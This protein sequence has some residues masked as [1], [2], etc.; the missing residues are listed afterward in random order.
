MKNTECQPMAKRLLS[1]LFAI[2]LVVGLVPISAYAAND[3]AG[4]ETTQSQEQQEPQGTEGVDAG[5]GNSD[6]A[7][8]ASETQD[9]SSD[10]Q[11]TASEEDSVTQAENG[12]N[13]V[14]QFASI[15]GGANAVSNEPSTVADKSLT[16]EVDGTANITNGGSGYSHSWETSNSSIATAKDNSGSASWGSRKTG[17]AIVTGVKPGTVTI[18]HKYK[19]GA[20]IPS[21]KSET[22]TVEVVKAP[23][24][25]HVKLTG[26][27]V[28]AVYD[29][30][31]HAAGTAT[32][33]GNNGHPVVVEYQKADGSWTKNPADITA[34]AVADSTTVNVRASVPDYYDGYVTTTQALTIVQHPVVFSGDLGPST[35]TDNGS[36]NATHYT[37]G[38]ATVLQSGQAANVQASASSTFPGA[39]NTTASG[40]AAAA[41]EAATKSTQ[42]NAATGAATASQATSASNEKNDK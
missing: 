30:E 19:S 37:A 29:G 27:S 8:E 21:D 23:I 6:T 4:Q 31:A 22:F 14:A 33:S 13:G 34:T 5:S 11:S 40:T 17:K 9:E 41:S 32:V 10:T 20:L 7:N 15:L 12:Q 1:V 36:N 38:K 35:K 24:A 26:T 3:E 18:T 25:K 28:N 2:T 42:S 16:V 39:A